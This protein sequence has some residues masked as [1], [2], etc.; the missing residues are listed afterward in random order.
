MA[1]EQERIEAGNCILV[2]NRHSRRNSSVKRPRGKKR[3]VTPEEIARVNLNNARK[4]LQV[5][6]N[7]N[8]TIG[9]L[10][11]DL[12]YNHREEPGSLEQAGKDL[13][14]YLRK[15]RDEFKAAGDDL[16]YIAV[17]ERG[18][19]GKIHH[20]VLMN[21]GVLSMER[22]GM[23]WGMGYGRFE[24]VYSADLT[25]LAD[26]IFKQGEQSFRED[27]TASRKR[28]R[29]SKNLVRPQP[30]QKRI[31]ASTWKDVPQP[32]KGYIVVADSIRMGFDFFGFPWMEYRLCKVG[33][34]PPTRDWKR[35]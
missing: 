3:E 30:K 27:D 11:F 14:K 20:H 12:H 18:K 33:P 25:T 34:P 6:V 35:S 31:K 16:K 2:K 10:W 17:T 29:S 7:A 13:T 15:V 8:F 24:F 9:D 26:Y 19:E 23:I 28:W 1:Y 4:K 32:P 22:V 5:L 21:A